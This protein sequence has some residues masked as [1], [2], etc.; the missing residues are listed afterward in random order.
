MSKVVYRVKRVECN[1]CEKEILVET[2][3]IDN[4]P[5]NDPKI[6][7]PDEEKWHNYTN[8]E[9]GNALSPKSSRHGPNGYSVID[10]FVEEVKASD[11][12]GSEPDFSSI[13]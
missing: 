8:C 1:R 5:R 6:R 10:P 4:G 3:A 7:Y 13:F 11:L 9:C 12:D 2:T